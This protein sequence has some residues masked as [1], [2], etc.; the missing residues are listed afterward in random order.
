MAEL[1]DALP[2]APGA[3]AMPARPFRAYRGTEAYVFVCYAHADAA[4]VFADLEMLDGAGVHIWYDEG[5]EPGTDWRDELAQAL[6]GCALFLYFVSRRS[7]ASSHCRQEVNF[8]LNR[9]R[10]VLVVYLEEVALPPALEFSLSDRQAIGRHLYAQAD[11]GAR[12]VDSIRDRASDRPRREA[13]AGEEVER[14][15][16]IAVLPL[17][18][19][20]QDDDYLGEGIAA[21]L[22]TGL[23]RIQDLRVAPRAAAFAQVEHRQD[24]GHIGAKLGVRHVLDGTL[25]RSGDRLR[26]TTDLIDAADGRTLWSERFDRVIEDIFDVQEQIADAVADALSSEFGIGLGREVVNVGTRD[27]AA[28]QH[29]L[30]ACHTRYQL[31]PSGIAETCVTLRKAIEADPQFL[32]AHLLL[33][34]LLEG[35]ERMYGEDHGEEIA[36]V[37]AAAHGLDRNGARV[38]WFWKERQRARSGPGLVDPEQDEALFREMILHAEHPAA[39]GLN[40]DRWFSAGFDVSDQLD[41]GDRAL[42]CYALLLA[43]AGLHDLARVYFARSN[44]DTFAIACCMFAQGQDDAA[45]EFLFAYRERLPD[46]VLPRIGLVSRL[47]GVGRFDTA[48]IEAQ[49]VD[50]LLN[51]DLRALMAL[52]TAFW[53]DDRPVLEEFRDRIPELGIPPFFHALTT[54]FV[55]VDLAVER[56]WEAFEQRDFLLRNLRLFVPFYLPQRVWQPML[57]RPRCIELLD[58]MRLGPAW[59]GELEERA[60]SLLERLDGGAQRRRHG[61]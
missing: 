46:V 59:A 4:E 42:S 2:T 41:P 57:E 19:I 13:P 56:F 7:L 40:P 43:Q 36:A 58:A 49:R 6:A 26:V 32:Q 51:D 14:D 35:A 27:A 48:A 45:L 22:V 17:R 23:A 21:E 16:S 12:L 33:I 60:R 8:A 53:R 1:F 52:Q 61:F 37:E 34:T 18:T 31:T 54:L 9:K 5:I 10:R 30:H 28:Y 15:R 38:N 11:Y 55:D 25:R 3:T 47:Q 44:S 39:T 50:P 24:P 20:G 29:Y